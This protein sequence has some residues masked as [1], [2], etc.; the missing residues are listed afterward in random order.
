MLSGL[1]FN[2]DVVEAAWSA[3]LG[4]HM[5]VWFGFDGGDQWR[6]RREAL[7]STLRWNTK[8]KFVTRVVQF[9]SEPLYDSV[10]SPDDLANEIYSMKDELHNLNIPV[11]ISELAYGY[12]KNGGAE[13]V[14]D[15][16]DVID[17]HMLPYFSFQA[18][19]AWNAWPLVTADLN[20]FVQNGQGK[21]IWLSQNGWPSKSYPGVEPNSPYAVAD[22]ENEKN[23]YQLLDSK[24]EYFKYVDGGGVGWFWHIYS[25]SQEPG[26]GLYDY[27]G[28]PKFYF[29]P[30][31]SC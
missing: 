18:S 12:Q 26:Y 8:A 30:R 17:A 2:D 21:K 13:Q 25:D 16:I 11:T 4:L 24:C 1:G 7:L 27:S 14:M 9:G 6:R 28:N 23:Y 31:T 5:L 29:R 3:G 15:A 19:T 20:W 22:I 10:L